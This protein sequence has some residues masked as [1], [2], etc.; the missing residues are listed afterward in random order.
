MR[1]D[2]YLNGCGERLKTY[3][4]AKANSILGDGNVSDDL[5][6]VAVECPAYL[7]NQISLK[8]ESAFGTLFEIFTGRK[9]FD[10]NFK[11]FHWAAYNHDSNGFAFNQV[12]RYVNL[13]FPCLL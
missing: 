2:F 10:S 13:W 3:L 9:I 12:G 11:F 4:I 8:S 1:N 7:H 6:T 5:L